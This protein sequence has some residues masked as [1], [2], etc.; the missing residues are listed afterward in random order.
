MFIVGIPRRLSRFR[1]QY[2]DPAG[3]FM[4]LNSIGLQFRLMQMYVDVAHECSVLEQ[5]GFR[6][7]AT[8]GNGKETPGFDPDDAWVYVA[9]CKSRPTRDDGC[10]SHPEQ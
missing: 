7:L 9:A 1:Q 3:R 6:V 2:A 8:V 4:I 10:H 5:M